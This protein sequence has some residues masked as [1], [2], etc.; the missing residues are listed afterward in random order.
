MS[1]ITVPDRALDHVLRSF[2]PS[3]DQNVDDVKVLCAALIEKMLDQQC[4]AAEMGHTDDVNQC[5]LS[6]AR[7]DAARRAI[8]LIELAQMIAVKAYFAKV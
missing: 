4:T 2:N 6:G 3:G 1:Q 5:R 7:H 8:E